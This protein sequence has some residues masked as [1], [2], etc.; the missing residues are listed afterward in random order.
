[1]TMSAAVLF[2]ALYISID[3]FVG[4]KLELEHVGKQKKNKS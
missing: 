3:Q 2:Q 4:V 1:M